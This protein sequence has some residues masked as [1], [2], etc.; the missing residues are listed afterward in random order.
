MNKCPSVHIWSDAKCIR[1][2]GHDG[3]C[4]SKAVRNKT[5][6]TITRAWWSSKGGAFKSHHCYETKYPT[7]AVKEA[8]P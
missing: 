7:N 8:R 2:A 5:N 1:E 3:Y 6:G 4:Y